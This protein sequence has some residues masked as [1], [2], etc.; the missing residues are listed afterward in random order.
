M[1]TILP[2]ASVRLILCWSSRVRTLHPAVHLRPLGVRISL[3]R[4]WRVRAPHPVHL[5]HSMTSAVFGSRVSD[6]RSLSYFRPCNSLYRCATHRSFI[7]I[8]L[9]NSL[10]A[11]TRFHTSPKQEWLTAPANALSSRLDGLYMSSA[12]IL[13]LPLIRSALSHN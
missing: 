7:F 10:R 3:C 4:T 2:L 9:C 6:T 12:N 13:I 1:T 8:H 11:T 5:S